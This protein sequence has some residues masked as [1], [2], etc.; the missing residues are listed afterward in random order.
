MIVKEKPKAFYDTFERKG[1]GQKVTH[2]CP[3]CGHGTAHKLIAELLVELDIQDR[4]IFLSPVG[5]SVFAYYYMDTGNIQCAHGRAPAVGTGIR[6]THKDAILISYQGDG[7]LAAIGTAEIIHAA[8]RGENMTVFFINNAIYGMTG[9]QMAPT[10][11]E[12]QKTLTTPLGRSSG[13]DGNP[14]GMAEL[15]NAIKA[16]VYIERVSLSTAGK[17]L[18]A[19]KVFKKALENQI[20]KKGFSFVEVLSPCPI[21]WKMDPVEARSWMQAQLEPIYPVKNF[22]D[23]SLLPPP[24]D[25]TLPQMEEKEMKQ[26]LSAGGAIP[27]GKNPAPDL[28]QRVKIAGFGGQGVLSAGVLLAN[29]AIARGYQATWLP[30]YGPEMRGGKANASVIFSSRAIG[31]PVVA[32][33]NVLIALNTPSLISF[34]PDVER[35]G[36]IMVNSTLISDKVKREDVDVLYIPAS[37]MAKESGVMAT[38]NVIMLTIY[39]KYKGLADTEILKKIL[40]LSVKR[41]DAVAVNLKMMEKALTYFEEELT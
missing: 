24:H 17:V 10:T 16:P 14:I 38:A 3:G 13:R 34:E 39:L 22:R 32:V 12:G 1:A 33:P 21:N 11:L 19:R 30:S 18:K 7:D 20:E 2:Y 26:L 4:T 15:M 9:G 41:K 37:E 8:N 5:C 23:E 27:E 29:Y 31:S 28:E 25:D 6:R 40:P 35:G 36:L